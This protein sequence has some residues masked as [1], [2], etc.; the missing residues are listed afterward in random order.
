MTL[1][2]MFV[3]ETKYLIN[4]L[5]DLILQDLSSEECNGVDTVWWNN[6]EQCL[7]LNQIN[8]FGSFYGKMIS[9]KLNQAD[10][11]DCNGNVLQPSSI[12][13]TI[14]MGNSELKWITKPTD[15]YL[16]PV[17][18]IYGTDNIEPLGVCDSYDSRITINPS[19]YLEVLS[20]IKM[21]F[22]IEN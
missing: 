4:N 11:I 1:D 22:K 15:L 5:F 13:N 21:V 8:S 6:Q 17:I 16:S 7:D 19:D 12:D 14:F 3:T 18:T 10:N 9:L 2:S 20:F